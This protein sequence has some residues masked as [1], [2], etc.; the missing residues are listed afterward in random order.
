MGEGIRT[1]VERSNGSVSTSDTHCWKRLH[2]LGRRQNQ[3][4]FRTQCFKTIKIEH[5]EIVILPILVAFQELDDISCFM[6][7][8]LLSQDVPL[9][10]NSPPNEQRSKKEHELK[11]Y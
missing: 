3:T 7:L 6:S 8:Y 2:I 5:G 9:S 11:S 10:Q 4:D 1:T